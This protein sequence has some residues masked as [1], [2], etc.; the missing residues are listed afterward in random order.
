MIH[1]R[2]LIKETTGMTFTEITQRIR[3]EKAQDMLSNTN[4]SVAAISEEV[5]YDA[6]EHFI[7]LFKKYTKMTPSA[8]RKINS[9]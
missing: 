7:R 9:N 5:G 3:M 8:Y 2:N 1:Y 4:L 6:P